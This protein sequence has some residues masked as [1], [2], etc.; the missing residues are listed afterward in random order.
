MRIKIVHFDDKGTEVL[1][2]I[3]LNTE[4]D[5]IIID[6]ITKGLVDDLETKIKIELPNTDE[7]CDLIITITNK[8][9]YDIK[10]AVI[11]C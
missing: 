9:K 11:P 8:I 4:T 6:Q 5:P 10:R 2:V 7:E 3:D 1:K